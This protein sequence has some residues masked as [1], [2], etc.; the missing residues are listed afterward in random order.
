[1][2]AIE[3]AGGG[4]TITLRT[5]FLIGRS[6][7]CDLRIEEAR[8]SG[9]HARL[10]WTGAVWEVRDLGSKNGTFVGGQRLAPGGRVDLIAGDVIGLGGAE[11]PAPTFVL[12]DSAAPVAGARSAS[13]D[14][15]RFASDGLITL[16]DD[17][18]PEVSVVEGRDGQWIIE[19]EG[20]VRVASEGDTVDA[21]GVSWV[22]DLVHG[23]TSTQGATPTT[24]ALEDIGL[25]FAVSPDEERV[26]LTVVS[27]A[28]ETLLPARSYHYLLVTLA[29]ARLGAAAAPP[30]ERGWLD[31]DELCRM[32]ATD[33]LRLNV[34][35]WRARKQLAA[36]GIQ[37]AANVVE[38]R[39]G[40]GRI[41]LGVDRVEVR[42]AP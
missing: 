18:R 20:G 6:P 13:S 33:E 5:R 36:L 38:R 4:E 23:V 9:E 24:P 11:P 19:A 42:R 15:V 17:D 25:R 10:R 39:P 7:A 34:D 14:L 28:G 1:M 26:D 30:A 32:L 40:T 21:G 12:T 22:L 37:G 8:V 29:R 16:P 27:P 41:R 31:R 35:I 2:G 3:R